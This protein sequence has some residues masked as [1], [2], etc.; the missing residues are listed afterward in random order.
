MRKSRAHN[1]FG[2]GFTLTELCIGMAITSLVLTATLSFT[3]AVAKAWRSS[4]QEEAAVTVAHVTTARVDAAIRNAIWIVQYR[5]GSIDN[6]STQ[7]AVLVVWRADRNNDGSAQLSELEMLAYDRAA[8]V[9]RRYAPKTLA[10]DPTML[11]SQLESTALPE[12]LMILFP[13]TPVCA[14]VQGAR[15]LAYKGATD[16]VPAVEMLVRINQPGRGTQDVSIT[17][18]LR[19]ARS[20]PK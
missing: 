10:A 3:M 6:S 18:V 5:E 15:I 13:Q 14:K 9:I 19:G 20:N 4:E 17:S 11:P 16:R 1:H 12:A 8:K 7:D 2:G